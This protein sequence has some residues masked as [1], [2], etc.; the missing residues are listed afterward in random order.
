MRAIAIKAFGGSEQLELM[1]LPRP[2]PEPDEVLIEV[3]YAAVNAVD[4]KIREGMLQGYATHAFPLVLGWD[5]AGTVADMGAMVFG[6]NAGDQVYTSCPKPVIQHGCYAEYVAAKRDVIAP[7]PENLSFAEAAAIPLVALTAWQSLFDFAGLEAGQTVLV[8]AGAGGVGS[9]AIQLAKQAGATVLTTASAANH[10]YVLALGADHA[11][12]Y[13][14]M[15]FVDAVRTLRPDGV[16]IVLDTVGGEVQ[17]RSFKVLTSGG[18]LVSIVSPPDENLAHEHGL[19]AGLVYY[20]GNGAQLQKITE[21]L[22]AGTLKP[23]AVRE[24]PLGEAAQ[25]LEASKGGHV[26]GKIVLKVR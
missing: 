26:Q 20:Q 16:Q 17:E 15:D 14:A 12:D 7:M 13:R 6:F 1:D 8:H 21:M 9:L 25:A 4:W 11:I 19:K 2:V 3:R 10:D 24:M 23:P 18:V 22:E 5:A